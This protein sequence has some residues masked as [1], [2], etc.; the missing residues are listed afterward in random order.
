MDDFV[1]FG[2]VKR[3][4]IGVTFTEM[5]PELAKQKG[6]DELN[7]L[8]VQDVVANGAAKA[9]GIKPGDLITKIEDKVIYSSSDLQE[10]VAR[11]RPGDKVNLTVKSGGK[12]RNV[13]V[14]LKA[15]EDTKKTASGSSKS[16]T[17][18][19]NKLG[20]SF[21]PASSARKKNWASIRELW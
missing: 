20:A 5:S 18:I 17:E 2:S 14:T 13:T 10:R 16:A 8:Y 1:K 19:Y 15:E 6:L 3:G 7:G 9:A 11:L 12:E 21:V 4:L